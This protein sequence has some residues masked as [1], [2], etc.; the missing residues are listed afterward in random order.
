[1][2]IADSLE[3]LEKASL[4]NVLKSPWQDLPFAGC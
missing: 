4:P 3:I 2:F 1:M